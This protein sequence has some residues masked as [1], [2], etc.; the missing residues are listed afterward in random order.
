ME[1]IAQLQT[2]SDEDVMDRVKTNDNR[3]LDLLYN[4][5]TYKKFYISFRLQDEETA[6]DV[7]QET[8]ESIW[9]ARARYEAKAK[10]TTYFHTV[11]N[12]KIN[13][14]LRARKRQP[15]TMPIDD[16]DDWPYGHEDTVGE[17]AA[18]VRDCVKQLF[19]AIR[20]LPDQQRDVVLLHGYEGKTFTEIA[21]ELDMH[22]EAAKTTWRRGREKLKAQ[23]TIGWHLRESIPTEER[24]DDVKK[25]DTTLPVEQQDRID[26]VKI[27]YY[28]KDPSPV[29]RTP[30]PM[31]MPSGT[32]SMSHLDIPKISADV[33]DELLAEFDTDIFQAWNQ[34]TPFHLDE[35]PSS[36]KFPQRPIS[37]RGKLIDWL[38]RLND[39]FRK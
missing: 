27:D 20:Q 37:L 25:Q 10:F 8:W 34:P 12:N 30:I 32:G 23:H 15:E 2:L 28:K 36:L 5:Y 13:D 29:P 11:L 35:A 18:F 1:T 21:D 9:N 16:P 19:K 31:H 14:K 33:S 22:L 6:M 3:A 39:F 26:D 17:D 24:S 4:R 38:I 7:Y